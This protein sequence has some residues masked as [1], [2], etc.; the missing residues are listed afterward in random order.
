MLGDQLSRAV[1][2][3]ILPSAMHLSETS[4]IRDKIFI[5]TVSAGF[6]SRQATMTCVSIRDLK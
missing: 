1:N 6:P 3:R 5:L 4:T 2:S